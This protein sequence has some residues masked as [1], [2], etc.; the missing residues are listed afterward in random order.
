MRTTVL[1]LIATTISAG[2]AVRP[3]PRMSFLDN[4]TVRVGADLALGGAITH[5]SHRER[6]NNLV[7]SYDLGRQ[8]QMSHYSGPI[9][10]QPEG[11]QLKSEWAGIGWNPIQTGDVFGHAARVLEHHNDGRELYVKCRPM[12][13]PLED[14]PGECTY[15]SWTTLEDASVVM[16]FRV[17]NARRDTSAYPARMQELPAIY[18]VSRLHRFIAYTGERPFIGEPPVRIANDWRR[19][20]P[21]T[22]CIAT[23]GWAAL[24]GDDDW[25]VGVSGEDTFLFDGGLYQQ[26][27]SDDVRDS[28]TAYVAPVRM[29]TFDHDIDYR[30]R[31]VL[32]LGN[33]EQIRTRLV[34]RAQRTPPSWAFADGRDHWHVEGGPDA[35]RPVDGLWRVPCSHGRPRLVGPVRCWRAEDAP[36][37]RIEAGWRGPATGARLLWRCL[38]DDQWSDARSVGFDLPTDGLVRNQRIDLGAIAT[39]RG[40]ITGLALEPAAGPAPDASFTLRS[41]QLLPR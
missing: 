20:W 13:W 21:W 8:I 18:L 40:L 10:F 25:G 39:Y 19:P 38:G 5:L 24:V 14:V 3:E 27:G 22:R 33:L 36:V 41:V 9:P 35:G 30:Y 28:S 16:R 7:N 37:V 32:T 4:G 1:L 23:E 11:K 29:E 31:T 6:P 26:A 2:E 17:S 34:A 15:E 12:Q